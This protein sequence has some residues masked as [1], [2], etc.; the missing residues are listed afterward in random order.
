MNRDTHHLMSQCCQPRREF[1]HRHFYLL[2]L[3]RL[4]HVVSGNIASLSYLRSRHNSKERQADTHTSILQA[5][6]LLIK[7]IVHITF[8]SF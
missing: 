8:Y 7:I 5:R 1:L 3:Y 6:Y 2:L 4:K